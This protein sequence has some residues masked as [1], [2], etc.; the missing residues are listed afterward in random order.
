MRTPFDEPPIRG[1]CAVEVTL[2]NGSGRDGRWD[3]ALESN[4]AYWW[5]A[6]TRTTVA[7]EK[8]A[9]RTF[10]LIGALTGRAA[11]WA[12]HPTSSAYLSVSGPGVGPAK[13]DVCYRQ[14]AL[15]VTTAGT[16]V[17][18]ASFAISA[19][20]AQAR[21]EAMESQ[22]R[23]SSQAMAG[24][25]FQP[26]DLPADA[27]A[28]A[29]FA[30]IFLRGEEWTAL[31]A[32]RRE[33]IEDWTALGG[34]L[35]L[36]GPPDAETRRGLGS[37]RSWPETGDADHDRDE[38]VRRIVATPAHD[39]RF[40]SINE[41]GMWELPGRLADP[42]SH[43][44]WVFVVLLAV[45]AVIGPVNLFWLAR[46]R[47]RHRVYWTT[48][49]LASA[50]SLVMLAMILLR[51][52][53]GGE[54]YRFT[55]VAVVP[56]S[57]RAAIVQEQVARTGLLL[58]TGFEGRE[59]LLGWPLPFMSSTQMVVSPLNVETAGN[60]HGGWFRSRTLQAHY[61]ETVRPTRAR[62]QVHFGPTVEAISSIEDTLDD[63]FVVDGAGTGWTAPHVPAGRRVTLGRA[64]D[65][66][67]WLGKDLG[68]AGPV[69]RRRLAP[70]LEARGYFFAR[71]RR[72]APIETLPS[73]RW[74]ESA[75]LYVGPVEPLQ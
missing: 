44:G 70:L 73:I 11:G 57:H 12:T 69:N 53:V 64:G 10:L 7:V 28:Y 4:D 25:R 3:L 72:G 74:K 68:G 50:A 48:P 13:V 37:I 6:T 41:D 22:L 5:S 46:G 67:A 17:E 29:G 40:A 54:G 38:V 55:T 49:L 35:C 34:T 14:L 27:R 63:L 26:A 18:S 21:W 33:A 8:G 23:A 42:G 2:R 32:D 43:E 1:T 31:P 16:A 66:S 30:L 36:V 39:P 56:Q 51:D 71:T 52:G 20:L 9:T 65:V 61:L 24:S 62:V 45:T 19:S 47:H 60:G 15:N 75:S 59:P 58:G